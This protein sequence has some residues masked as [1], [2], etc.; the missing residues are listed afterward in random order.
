MKKLI[1]IAAFILASSSLALAQDRGDLRSQ[2]PDAR[3]DRHSVEMHD[4]APIAQA[5][6]QVKHRRMVTHHRRIVRDHT[7]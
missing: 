2:H 5:K 4:R 6:H 3:N 7:K 1:G